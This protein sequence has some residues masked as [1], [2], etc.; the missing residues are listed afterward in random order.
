MARWS[1][2][3]FVGGLVFA[4]C[5]LGGSVVA[6]AQVVEA[7]PHD[8]NYAAEL[9][10][11]RFTAP[12]TDQFRITRPITIQ[13][14]SSVVVST[15]QVMTFGPFLA[16]NDQGANGAEPGTGFGSEGAGIAE[17][18]AVS[19]MA[20]SPQMLDPSANLIEIGREEF[21]LQP[22]QTRTFAITVTLPG[23]LSAVDI[24]AEVADDGFTIP[25]PIDSDGDQSIFFSGDRSVVSTDCAVADASCL[26][27]GINPLGIELGLAPV[28]ILYE[29]PGNCSSASFNANSLQG[30][31]LAFDQA[32]A[33]ANG[34]L[35]TIPDPSGSSTSNDVTSTKTGDSSKSI[36]VQVA[37]GTTFFTQE[38]TTNCNQP[39][40]GCSSRTTGGPGHGDVFVLLDNAPI[41]YWNTGNL[42]NSRFASEGEPIPPGQL[43]T[44]IIH[45]T[46]DD[47]QGDPRFLPGTLPGST[48]A[49]R[50]SIASLD[51]L[52]AL[53]QASS[54]GAATTA[55]VLSLPLPRY[56]PLNLAFGSSP[57]ESTQIVQSVSDN[58]ATTD[59]IKTAIQQV[60]S[61]MT[62][63]N[64]ATSV[65]EKIDLDAIGANGIAGSAAKKLAASGNP[66]FGFI[67]SE[68]DS[69]LGTLTAQP[70]TKT[71]M[72]T[73][74]TNS[75]TISS[76]NVGGS[77]QNVCLRDSTRTINLQIYWD[78][79]FGTFAYQEIPAAMGTVSLDV[80]AAAAATMK[81]LANVGW[82]KT[83]V[84]GESATAS[85]PQSIA[86]QLS[87]VAGGGAFALQPVPSASFQVHS[88]FLGGVPGG[89]SVGVAGLTGT[90]NADPGVYQQAFFIVDPAGNNDG[91][92][93]Q[94]I[95]VAASNASENAMCTS[96]PNDA[97]LG[98]EIVTCCSLAGLC[99]SFV[100]PGTGLNI[101]LEAE[102]NGGSSGTTASATAVTANADGAY[103][104][105]PGVDLGP[106]DGLIAAFTGR[107]LPS[108]AGQ[109]IRLWVDG[110]TAAG[111]GTQ[112]AMLAFDAT[113]QNCTG[114]WADQH[115][116][117]ST[118]VNG[119]PS[120][121]HNI[122]VVY[123]GP[124]GD[125]LDW[126]ELSFEAISPVGPRVQ[127]RVGDVG[128]PHDNQIQPW[129]SV[130]NDG[131]TDMTLNNLVLRYW[132]TI[133]SGAPQV[134]NVDYAPF[135]AQKVSGTFEAQ[136]APKQGG[137]YALAVSFPNATCFVPPAGSTGEIHLRVNKTDWS[138]YDETNDYSYDGADTTFADSS[139]ITAYVNGTLMWGNEP[140]AIPGAETDSSGTNFHVQYRVGD[141]GQPTDN[142]IKAQFNIVSD[143]TVSVPL[144]ELT[145]RYWFT[146]ESAVGDQFWCDYA[147][148]GNSNVTGTVVKL[149][150]PRLGADRYIQV[151][152]T[153]GAGSLFP[154][155][156]T[157]EIQT[158]LSAVD[159]SNYN[160]L[161]DY[162]Y[163]PNDTVYVASSQVTLYRN[164]TLVW[165]TEP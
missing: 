102:N 145:L 109:T 119:A 132:Y 117:H 65:L 3:Y 60:N 158:R 160:E 1:V 131:T 51:P 83:I 87:A 20:R 89:V 26:Q 23:A 2:V 28:T 165:G 161:N 56:V 27:V 50:N 111:G 98:T 63:A 58:Q 76:S 154:L 44:E 93:W 7:W 35:T 14:F 9:D 137:D 130:A 37:F 81:P 46:T 164:G 103:I 77:V 127:Y 106:L 4:L 142:A 69:L 157:G 62:A 140:A 94:T 17:T 113:S 47:I 53:A 163:N 143:N 54:G 33:V 73:T 29:P 85:F 43:P 13:G 75:T 136:L 95:A 36:Q 49:D 16:R 72:Q 82:V 79:L 134:L 100:A 90:T 61:S 70:T 45:F 124:P 39:P 155:G 11:Y 67:G 152:F 80:Q 97:A 156:S 110:P 138:N 78:Q 64:G 57:G 139:V 107:A 15:S 59:V 38:S 84:A 30:T 151:S 120:G 52:V 91:V 55:P 112:L 74:L 12:G 146:G 141:P 5:S 116:T 10:A 105:F 115:Q 118:V 101:H 148:L 162:S 159:W 122:F 86:E 104:E 31:S 147:R 121:T 88:G 24:R 133:D 22:G 48:Q 96:E 68:I 108:A 92:F 153:P 128:M 42:S 19:I 6:R 150:T 114:S 149:D 123:N 32:S 40:T 34:T 126:V 21:Q 25:D 71:T 125:S 135:G 18:F 99:D 129:V 66:A 144:Q 8:A 41:V